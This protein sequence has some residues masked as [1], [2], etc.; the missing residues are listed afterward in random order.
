MYMLKY[1]LKRLGLMF[2][3]LFG[4]TTM[5]FLLIKM[6]PTPG[7]EGLDPIK[8]LQE[9]MR[10]KLMGY[11]EPVMVQ[12]W[13]YMKNIFTKFDWGV[14]FK[15]DYMKP[16]TEVVFSRLPP[17]ILLN[18]YSLLFSIPV[19]IAFGIYAA[20]RKDKWQDH[21]VSTGVMLLISVPGFVIAFLM[22][23]IFG[24]KL[25][26]LPLTIAPLSQTGGKWVSWAMF[27]SML[28]PILTM[29]FGSIAGL[30]RRTRAELNEVLTNDYMLLART[31]GLTKG[32]ATTRHA[33]KNAM[34]PILPGIIGGFLS[35]LSGS[36]IYEQIFGVPG[37]GRLYIT[38]INSLDY[39]LFLFCT[40]F[41]GFIG[42]T[43]SIVTDLSRGFLDPRIR[44][45]ARK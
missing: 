44:V 3:T 5:C 4:I 24:Y 28:L 16:V 9:I 36:M 26:W 30:T 23:Y 39:D 14:S 12:Y 42:L 1:S 17:T 35:V 2:F 27:V 8:N 29:S 19:G 45:G 15:V 33:L 38:A 41:Y 22:Q 13:L 40:V 32:Q 34:V 21:V 25:A 31:K 37:V 10:R 43:G 18:L 20:L 7:I 11:D 6:L